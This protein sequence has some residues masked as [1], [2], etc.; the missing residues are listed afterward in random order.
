M[1]AGTYSITGTIFPNP[2][3]CPNPKRQNY[4]TT[5]N[6]FVSNTCAAAWEVIH[7]ALARS[8]TIMCMTYRSIMCPFAA[9]LSQSERQTT[10]LPSPLSPV[11]MVLVREN[12][13]AR[14]VNGRHTCS[15]QANMCPAS[16]RLSQSEKTKTNNAFWCRH[17]L[18]CPRRHIWAARWMLHWMPDCQIASL[19]PSLYDGMIHV[20]LALHWCDRGGAANAGGMQ[21]MPPN[22]ARCIV[23]LLAVVF[24]VP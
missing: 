1:D 16:A 5:K 20:A 13:R 23:F 8:C 10:T 15:T 2:F 11:I 24:A 14:T 7:T 17:Q 21:P 3:V 4:A 18:R 12:N 6:N 22:V 19:P 9:R